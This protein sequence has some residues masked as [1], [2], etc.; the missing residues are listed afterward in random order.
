VEN[1]IA[2][3]AD[4]IDMKGN[5]NRLNDS[6]KKRNKGQKYFNTTESLN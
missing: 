4:E 3:L 1:T 2:V 6:I 5:C